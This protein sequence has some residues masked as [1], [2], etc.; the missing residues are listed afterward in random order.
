MP[1]DEMQRLWQS[2][3]AVAAPVELEHIRRKAGKLHGDIR[4]RNRTEFVT[5]AAAIAWFIW[6]GLRAHDW[7][8]RLTYVLLIAGCLY[9]MWHLRRHGS[10]RRLPAEYGLTDAFSFHCQE[11]ARQRDLLRGVMRWYMAPMFPGYAACVIS[12]VRAGSWLAGAAVA[13]LFASLTW[14]VWWMNRRA[15]N[16]LNQEIAELFSGEKRS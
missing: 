12:V 10:T 3:P 9:A 5:G 4:G 1:S 16:K 7:L 11:L 13:A 8:D 14:L 6:F 2:Q 15:V